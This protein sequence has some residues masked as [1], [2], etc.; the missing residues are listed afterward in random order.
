MR[1]PMTFRSWLLVVSAFAPACA[2]STAGSAT[3]RDYARS[4]LREV[5]LRTLAVWVAARPAVE[6]E[7]SL[8][9]VK[10]FDAPRLNDQLAP[11]RVDAVQQRALL[12]AL[13]AW[14][15]D[16]GFEVKPAPAPTARPTLREVLGAADADAVLVVRVAPVD[17]FSVFQQSGEQQ[18]IETGDPSSQVLT[19][20]DQAEDRY[21]RLLIGQAFLF[22]PRSRVRLWSRQIPD[23]PPAGRLVPDDP[24]LAY[25]FV[26]RDVDEVM[27]GADKARRAAA[28]FVP[29]M[30]RTFPEPREGDPA[31]RL[32]LQDDSIQQSEKVQRFFDRNHVAIEL[33]VGWE[34]PALSSTARTLQPTGDVQ[35]GPAET[36]LPDVG[37]SELAS[38]GSIEAV[39][40]KVTWVAPG[41]TTFSLGF[42]IGLIPNDLV[43]TVFAEAVLDSTS[44]DQAVELRA[45][46]GTAVGGTLAVGRLVPLAPR[47]FLLPEVG[48]FVDVYVFDV[49]PT[50]PDGTHPVWGAQGELSL[51][52]RFSG[53]A[54]LF[55]RLGA[56][57]RVGADFASPSP[58]FGSVAV[59]TALGLLF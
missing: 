56:A 26:A 43:R 58:L 37:T 52:Y 22:E 16:Q 24:F 18:M 4:E 2:G 23:F 46:G 57:G 12:E 40:P 36:P 27:D 32:A 14:G 11:E 20:A 13:E 17:R 39:R 15:A 41:G 42:E 25:G 47:L 38:M 1:R 53:W 6:D 5:P 21:G 34:L 3:S 54:P 28:A 49:S 51:L 50:I 19:T 30:L 35:Q 44:V 8:D 59:T 45:S 48:T 10:A 7:G 33:G 55:I 9:D 29:A 31:A